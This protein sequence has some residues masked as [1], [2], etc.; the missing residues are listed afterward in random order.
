MDLSTFQSALLDADRKESSAVGRAV[1]AG[2]AGLLG[3]LAMSPVL[4]LAWALGALEPSAFAGLAQIVGLGSSFPLGALI[5]LGG[6]ATT[7]PLL[8]VAWAL[9]FP[10]ETLPRRGVVHAV[11]VW[12]GFA[13]AFYSGQTGTALALYLALTFVAHVVYGA[14]LGYIYGRMATIPVYEI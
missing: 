14:V 11:I 4:L 5:F 7:L 2:F 6:G 10:G 12:T 9:F 3:M 13:I 1:I 8:F